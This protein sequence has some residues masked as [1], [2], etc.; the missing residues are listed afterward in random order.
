MLGGPAR[1]LRQQNIAQ[2]SLFLFKAEQLAI[3]GLKERA[4]GFPFHASFAVWLSSEQ[5]GP[6]AVS[7][8]TGADQDTRIIVEIERG[9]ADLD[10]NGKHPLATA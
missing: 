3:L 1:H 10:A 6:G 5:S 7:E 4:G 9:A 2:H 8:Q